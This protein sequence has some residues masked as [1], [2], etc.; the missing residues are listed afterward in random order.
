M[1]AARGPIAVF[2]CNVPQDCVG[3]NCLCGTFCT[4]MFNRCT[5]SV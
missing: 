1:V 4:C 3:K 5:C 2:S